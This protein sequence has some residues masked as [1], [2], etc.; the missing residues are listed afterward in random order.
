MVS[1][2]ILIQSIEQENIKIR[3]YDDAPAVNAG[4]VS[5]IVSIGGIKTPS[6]EELSVAIK[7]YQPGDI[8][9]IE[10]INSDGEREIKQ[11]KLAAREDGTSYLGIGFFAPPRKGLS[12]ALFKFLSSI[13]DPQVFYEPIYD[14]NFA[15]FIY[16]LL[17]WVVIINISV[18]LIN[19]L[20][21][22]IFDG[23]RFFYLTVWGLT[24]KESWARKAFSF[25]TWMILAVLVWVMIVWALAVF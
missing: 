3:V 18:A 9:D 11:I 15:W 20:P 5:P 23:G 1:Q 14:E 16:N 6:Q 22:G 7:R 21:V 12:G 4:L 13:K 8:V 24:G 19:M 25:T 2:E 17:W 10:F